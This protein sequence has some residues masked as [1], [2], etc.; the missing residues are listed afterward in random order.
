MTAGVSVATRR[1]GR[2]VPRHLR[3]IHA[4]GLYH[5][6][7]RG[8][9]KRVI[10]RKPSDYDRFVRLLQRGRT[11]APVRLIAFCLMPTHFHLVLCPLASDALSI[12]MQW[13]TTSYAC[14]FRRRTNTSGYGH[15][16]QRRFWAAQVCDEPGFIRL[17]RYVEGNASRAHLVAR[18]EA[19]RWTSLVDRLKKPPQIID[20]CPLELP[21]PWCEWVNLG[22]D[23]AAVDDIRRAL[24]KVR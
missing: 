14:D 8:N 24:R 1:A 21:A 19:W 23:D 9:D 2:C 6:V 10:Y 15:V 20:P 13:V 18:A 12:Y 17:M 11:R 22:L 4:G 3:I 16:F 7:N 5:V